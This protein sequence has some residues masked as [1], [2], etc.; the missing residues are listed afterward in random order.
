MMTIDDFHN[1][2]VEAFP[3][4]PLWYEV[5][6]NDEGKE[7]PPTYFYYTTEETQILEADN[8]VYWSQTPVTLYLV[9]TKPHGA[10]IKD[11]KAF[12][13]ANRLPF[14]V[15]EEDWDDESN[16]WITEFNFTI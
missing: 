8:I 6:E 1:K 16:S 11:I 4:I 7:M 3:R 2:L 5:I 10:L 14:R 15:T 9:Q 13:N 12:L